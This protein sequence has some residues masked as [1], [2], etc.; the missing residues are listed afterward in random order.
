MKSQQ[1]ARVFSLAMALGTKTSFFIAC[2]CL[3]NIGATI[4]PATAAASASNVQYAST[5]STKDAVDENG[6]EATAEEIL[7]LLDNLY[8]NMGPE[9]D[10]VL[11]L[12][13]TGSGK[14]FVSCILSNDPTLEAKPDEVHG[15]LKIVDKNGRVS[16]GPITVSK[17]IAPDRLVD[18][19]GHAYFDCPG[20]DD[21]RGT[22]H[23]ISASY[24]IKKLINHTTKLKLVFVL[25]YTDLVSTAR[26]RNSFGDLALHANRM[27]TKFEHFGRS[28]MF[29]INKTPNEILNGTATTDKQFVARIA[30]KLKEIKV[31]YMKENNATNNA[32]TIDKNLK[33]IKFVD[34]MLSNNCSYIGIV[35]VVN[36]F[37][38]I[39]SMQTFIEHRLHLR[40]II[41]NKIEFFPEDARYINHTISDKSR[42]Y[43]WNVHANYR[44]NLKMAVN[45]IVRQLKHITVPNLERQSNDI[46]RL[47]ATL[48]D[49]YTSIKN[50][51]KYVHSYRDSTTPRSFLQKLLSTLMDYDSSR[52]PPI[53][54]R[55]TM[56]D[57]IFGIFRD[58]LID[59]D[60]TKLFTD[61]YAHYMNEVEF[62]RISVN[63]YEFLNHLDDVLMKQTKDI[64]ADKLIEECGKIGE[65]ET[66]LVNDSLHLEPFLKSIDQPT[67]YA[68]IRGSVV[69]FH[70][71]SA[72]QHV[73]K[74]HLVNRFEVKCD[75]SGLMTV[76]GSKV[77]LS[78]VINDTCW[79]NA[80]NIDIFSSNMFIVDTSI[81]KSTKN[82]L[83]SVFS[84][85]WI[86]TGTHEINLSG[87]NGANHSSQKAGMFDFLFIIFLSSML[88]IFGSVEQQKRVKTELRVKM[89]K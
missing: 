22:A 10:R 48:E 5:N 42:L 66:W 63:W 74:A 4:T 25:S 82:C 29:I 87:I 24:F 26:S 32:E 45:E 31:I 79:S 46:G 55:A 56:S 58:L 8:F 44:D 84:P 11:V 15:G 37:G 64:H 72:L 71:L 9:K 39:N 73:L 23:D 21:T 88:F 78:G 81:R 6:H 28:A 16:T 47:F 65:K 59:A 20:F 12:G 53:M 13:E 83:L 52:M 49:L 17:T 40:Q 38:P 18:E 57:E 67:L 77:T 36:N 80:K 3:L 62:L 75:P 27:F 19:Q 89:V 34:L 76:K 7:N 86:V 69:N 2:C 14:S 60:F 50:R 68:L 1:S 61:A 41:N 70:E 33:I 43:L 51:I 85:H 30:S 54:S 35:H